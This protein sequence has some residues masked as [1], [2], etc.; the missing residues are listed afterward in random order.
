M[1][2]SKHYF[3]STLAKN[4][5]C[6]LWYA[7]FS[8]SVPGEHCH[9]LHSFH[10]FSSVLQYSSRQFYDKKISFIVFFFSHTNTW[11]TKI[12][13]CSGNP[14]CNFAAIHTYKN[15]LEKNYALWLNGSLNWNHQILFFSLTEYVM[16]TSW[17][18]SLSRS[19]ENKW[20]A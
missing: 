5:P 6:V 15:C 2:I 4:Q 9:L 13:T 19:K 10:C 17:S 16:C 8:T 7:Y 12:I 14:T 3:C 1:G 20:D 11:K 18:S